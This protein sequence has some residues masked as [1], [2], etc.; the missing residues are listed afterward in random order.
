MRPNWDEMKIG[1]MASILA[2]KFSDP[3]LRLMLL[4]TWGCELVEGNTWGDTFWG[5][6]NG[7]GKNN[8]GKI[9]M[10]LRDMWGEFRVEQNDA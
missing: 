3:E 4:Q 5:V 6:C 10:E 7:K 2:A 1:F 9:L 8:L